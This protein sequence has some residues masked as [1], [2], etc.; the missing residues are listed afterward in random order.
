[1]EQRQSSRDQTRNP[2]EGEAARTSNDPLTPD[3][4]REIKPIQSI[5]WVFLAIGIVGLIAAM[6]FVVLSR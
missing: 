2:V 4:P 1:M 6:Y 5:V 3:L